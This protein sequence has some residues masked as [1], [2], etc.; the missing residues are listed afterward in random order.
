MIVPADYK[1]GAEAEIGGKVQFGKKSFGGELG[2]KVEGSVNF[3]YGDTWVFNSDKEAGEW[4]DD[5]KWDLA[6]KEGEKVSP[7]LWL[8][9]TITGWEPRT[10]DPE[11]TQ[12]EVGA[13]GVLKGAARLRQPD[14]GLVRQEDREGHRD[15][16]GD[17]GLGR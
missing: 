12:W 9:D 13:E 7:G 11:I 15:G 17:R 2:A 10:R 3:K 16:P 4:L 5:V 6:R 1:L 14:H 8:Y